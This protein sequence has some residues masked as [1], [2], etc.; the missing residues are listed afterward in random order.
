MINR[1]IYNNPIFQK[2][3]KTHPGKQK[4]IGGLL[5]HTRQVV[6]K[7]LE[8][9]QGLDIK[10][11]EETAMVHDI[12]YQDFNLNECQIM[13]ILATKGKVPYKIWRKSKCCELVALL[14]IADMWSAFINK[15]DK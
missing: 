10:E 9:N 2:K 15:N 14:L 3:C 5:L 8:L 12:N 13:A 1:D 6:K 7:A 4:E 11:V